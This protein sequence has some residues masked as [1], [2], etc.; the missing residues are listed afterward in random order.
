M[1]MPNAHQGTADSWEMTGSVV[2]IWHVHGCVA[3]RE[4][5]LVVDPRPPPHAQTNTPSQAT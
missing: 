3:P 5:C 2:G 4:L 1:Q